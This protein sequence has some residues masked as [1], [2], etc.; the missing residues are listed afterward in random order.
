MLIAASVIK[1]IL[2]VDDF[3]QKNLLIIMIFF[4]LL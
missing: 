1:A 4:I 2:V 3:K